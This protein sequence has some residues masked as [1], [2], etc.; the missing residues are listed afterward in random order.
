MNVLKMEDKI[1]ELCHDKLQMGERMRTLK[2][3]H[4]SPVCDLMQI[5]DDSN[6][7]KPRCD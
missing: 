1:Q 5:D 2:L 4:P 7:R 3:E 6:G